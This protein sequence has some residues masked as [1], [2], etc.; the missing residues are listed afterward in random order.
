MGRLQVENSKDETYS[1]KLEA[2]FKAQLE[3]EIKDLKKQFNDQRKP[4]EDK[5]T[6]GEILKVVIEK[7]LEKINMRS[8]KRETKT[9]QKKQG[10]GLNE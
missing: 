1:F 7:G 8:L 9:K 6:T 4:G 5:I 3:A 10:T 2:S